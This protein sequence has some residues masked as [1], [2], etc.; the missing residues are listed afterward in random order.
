MQQ[1]PFLSGQTRMRSDL[2]IEELGR[3]ISKEILGGIKM[4]G[5]EDKICEEIP[6]IYVEPTILG[7]FVKLQGTK[8]LEEDKCYS[9]EIEQ[10]TRWVKSESYL[11]PLDKY[12]LSVFEERLK[13]YP[14]IILVR[15]YIRH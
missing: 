10:I 15:D 7:F 6:A 12:L 1:T 13:N 3:I 9:F 2:E 4:G 8:G 14:E 5:L 11:L